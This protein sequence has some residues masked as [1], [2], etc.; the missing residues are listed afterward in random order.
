MMI[1]VVGI[2]TLSLLRDKEDEMG[3]AVGCAGVCFFWTVLMRVT[4]RWFVRHIPRDSRQRMAWRTVPSLRRIIYM[5][6]LLRHFFPSESNHFYNTYSTIP[7]RK[8]IQRLRNGSIFQL[9]STSTI[10]M[11]RWCGLMRLKS[12]P[13]VFLMRKKKKKYYFIL[14]G[15]KRE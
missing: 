8:M 5:T 15:P 13:C 6:S 2:S 3:S 1:V 9:F 4:R 12:L 7:R 10:I 11:I 14:V